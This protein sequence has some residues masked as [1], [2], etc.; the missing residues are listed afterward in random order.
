M[1]KRKPTGELELFK[2]IWEER[3]HISFLSGTPIKYFDVKC[4]AH[5]LNK[6]KYPKF[7][8]NKDNI[9]LLTPTEHNLLDAGTQLARDKYAFITESNWEKIT[10]LKEKLK[11]EY[12]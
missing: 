6:G 12:V 11:L 10:N 1:K 7:R 9:V 4:F 3:I 8:L 5:V 2:E